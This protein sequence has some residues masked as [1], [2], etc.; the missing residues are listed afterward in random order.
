MAASGDVG[1]TDR[2][3]TDRMCDVCQ[4]DIVQFPMKQCTYCG[5]FDVC[6]ACFN[7]IPNKMFVVHGQYLQPLIENKHDLDMIMTAIK[8]T[9][10]KHHHQPIPPIRKQPLYDTTKPQQPFP[11][12]PPGVR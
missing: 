12:Y 10:R 5:E 11:K 1:K 6:A 7:K 3:K 4:K 9:V 2:V 8:G